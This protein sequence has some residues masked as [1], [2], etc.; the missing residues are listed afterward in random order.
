MCTLARIFLGHVYIVIFSIAKLSL[1]DLPHRMPDLGGSI[2][3]IKII[4]FSFFS[5]IH[6]DCNQAVK[7]KKKGPEGFCL[8]L[9]DNGSLTAVSSQ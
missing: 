6:T 5:R 4:V 8:M 3:I 9:A 7:R 1:T 2:N